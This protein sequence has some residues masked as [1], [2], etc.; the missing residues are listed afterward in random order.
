AKDVGIEVANA[1][2][3]Q[4]TV[5]APCSGIVTEARRAGTLAMAGAPLVR[6]RADGPTRVDT[7]VT[8]EQLAEVRLGVAA[9]VGF[10]SN[11]AGAP[12]PG[13]VTRI[14]ETAEFPPTSLATPIVH[15]TRVVR[16]TVT[17]DDGGWAPPG[18]PVD[19]TLLTGSGT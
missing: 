13:R 15:M 14:A 19:V 1:K 11:A 6:V 7:F 2:V 17:I 18:T 9:E 8:P 16:V 3:A 12:L 10:D 4:A 5:V